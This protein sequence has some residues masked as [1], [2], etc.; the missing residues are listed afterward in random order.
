MS[1]ERIVAGCIRVERKNTMALL[2]ESLE[3]LP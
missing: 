2:K 1:P 3:D